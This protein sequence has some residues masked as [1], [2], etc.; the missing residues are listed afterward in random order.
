MHNVLT[1]LDI[2]GSWNISGPIVLLDVAHRW[3][4]GRSHHFLRLERVHG[5]V[6]APLSHLR[7]ACLLRGHSTKIKV[8]FI[9]G[10]IIVMYTQPLEYNG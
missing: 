10:L 6:A 1:K 5:D 9:K 8:V 3:N 7:G 4:M 2:R